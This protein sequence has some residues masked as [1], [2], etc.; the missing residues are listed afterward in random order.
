MQ[1]L[2]NEIQTVLDENDGILSTHA[3]FEMKLLDSVMK[4]SQRTN[5]GNLVRF[6]RYIDK[7]LTLSDGT[8][9]PVGAMIE[10]PHSSFIQDPQL[11][12]NPEVRTY[13]SSG[14]ISPK[15]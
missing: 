7:P 5:P 1:Q 13:D 3:L 8:H 10:A 11:Y 12:T 6:V 4:E 14:V 15:C 2:R 9:L